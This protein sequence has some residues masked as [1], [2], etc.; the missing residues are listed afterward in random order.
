MKTHLIGGILTALCGKELDAINYGM[1]VK[2]TSCKACIRIAKKH[3]VYKKRYEAT[4][5]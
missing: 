5:E 3:R 2:N 4:N 1:D